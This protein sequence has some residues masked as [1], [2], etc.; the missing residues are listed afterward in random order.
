MDCVK[1]DMGAFPPEIQLVCAFV[2]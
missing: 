1:A 2:L